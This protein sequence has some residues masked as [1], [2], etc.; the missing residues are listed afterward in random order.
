MSG[1]YLLFLP[2]SCYNQSVAVFQTEQA[3]VS[4]GF[5]EGVTRVLPGCYHGVTCSLQ[6]LSGSWTKNGERSHFCLFL[7]AFR[8]V[9]TV[10]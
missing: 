3:R 7:S 5:V 9:W 10:N 4:C 8:L 2:L 6:T 1:L